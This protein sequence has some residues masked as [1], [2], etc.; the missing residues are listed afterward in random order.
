MHLTFADD[1]SRKDAA[2]MLY[3]LFMIMNNTPE[4]AEIIEYDVENGPAHKTVWT[5]TNAIIPCSAVGLINAV[6]LGLSVYFIKKKR[7]C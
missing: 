4:P 2:V 5:K 3:R 1:I 6:A 7:K